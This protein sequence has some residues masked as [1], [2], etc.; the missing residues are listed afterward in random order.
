MCV[1]DDYYPAFNL[2]HVTLVDTAGEGVQ[3]ITAAGPVVDGKQYELDAIVYAT[4]FDAL[5]GGSKFTR[6]PSWTNHVPDCLAY[7]SHRLLVVT[8]FDALGLVG[9]GGQ[10][11]SI[12]WA[13]G[14]KTLFGIHTAGF[15][16]LAIMQGPQSPSVLS[17]MVHT[18]EF[19]ADHITK[20][21]AHMKASGKRVVD[22]DP[23]AEEEWTAECIRLGAD[24]VQGAC[25][26]WYNKDGKGPVGPYTDLLS[27]Y[28][29]M[30]EEDWQHYRFE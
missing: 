4:G 21:V 8:D 22:I 13:D 12:K 24:K 25:K 26:N 3:S 2:P 16:N 17:N 30:V 14:P 28:K 23:A 20:L 9:P 19:Q 1:H 18:S 6:N 7:S 15:P 11:L 10:Q 29:R 5:G 27:K